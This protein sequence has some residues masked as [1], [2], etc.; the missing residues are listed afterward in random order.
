MQN[1]STTI[2]QHSPSAH[3]AEEYWLDTTSHIDAQRN[4]VVIRGSF[5]AMQQIGASKETSIKVMRSVKERIRSRDAEPAAWFFGPSRAKWVS[6]RMDRGE[7]KTNE[8][9]GRAL[10]GNKLEGDSTRPALLA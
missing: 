9:I 8:E 4:C 5:M 7:L 6:A 2:A 3:R 1:Q 10:T